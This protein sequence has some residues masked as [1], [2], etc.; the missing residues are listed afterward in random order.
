M[1]GYHGKLLWAD[2]TRG[3]VWDEP[4]REDYV[5]A[6]IGGSGLAVRYLYDLLA[7]DADPLD[8]ANPLLLMVGPLTGTHAPLSGRHTV[9]GRS[10]LTGV[11]GE[12]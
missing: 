8:E 11:L 9:V 12:S 2:L 4:L 7:P 1:D 3:T 10:P 5:R 6:F